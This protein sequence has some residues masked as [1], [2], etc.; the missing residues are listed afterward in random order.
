MNMQAPMK[1]PVVAADGCTYDKQNILSHL[2]RS[3]Y[4]PATGEVRER[5]QQAGK[6]LLCGAPFAAS[7]FQ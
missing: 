3:I 4:S 5:Q 2:Q 7:A 1:D 6:Q